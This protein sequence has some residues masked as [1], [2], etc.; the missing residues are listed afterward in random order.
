M[1]ARGTTASSHAA[2]AAVGAA[3]QTPVEVAHSAGTGDA[4][5]LMA[6]YDVAA[7]A[8][9]DGGAGGARKREL[10]AAADEYEEEE[11]EDAGGGK[12]E[13]KDGKLARAAKR[14]R[15]HSWQQKYEAEFGLLAIERDSV[16]G[17]VTLAMCGFCKAFG[18]EG[19]YE[20][21]VAQDAEQ[22]NETKKRRRR[23]L[24]TTKFF[25]AFRVDNIR[26]HLQGAHPRRWAEYETLPKQDAIRARYLQMQG[27]FQYDN[28]SMVEDV[29]LG[30]SALSAESDMAY[31]Q[32]QA[33][34]LAHSTL[35]DAHHA[36]SA[37]HVAVAA[38]SSLNGSVS[39]PSSLTTSLVSAARYGSECAWKYL[40]TMRWYRLAVWWCSLSVGVQR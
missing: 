33:Q 15:R 38:A 36:P 14:S 25:R 34:A 12:D 16:S 9:L 7:A 4:S 32:A 24:T 28:L 30:G 6:E 18:R 17:D 5:G 27:E 31:A 21:L 11:E 29:V 23:S 20:Q 39:T 13:L 22:G 35:A 26:S 2:D 19:K 1:D 40:L 37:A 10:E 8:D 3:D